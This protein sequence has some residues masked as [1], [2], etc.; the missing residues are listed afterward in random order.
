LGPLTQSVC[1]SIQE[2]NRIAV[3]ENIIGAFV[4]HFAHSLRHP[5]QPG[6]A[7]LR[8]D[9]NGVSDGWPVFLLVRGQ[10]QYRLDDCDALIR[11]FAQV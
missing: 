6:I 1:P 3:A 7:I 10:L 2:R 11:Q 8:P 4:A 9:P 5:R